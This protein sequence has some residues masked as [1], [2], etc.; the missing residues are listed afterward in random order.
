MKVYKGQAYI[1]EKEF[2][3]FLEDQVKT[4]KMTA[5]EAFKQYE[6]FKGVA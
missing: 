4:F 2:K 6:N 3:E 5:K 1:T